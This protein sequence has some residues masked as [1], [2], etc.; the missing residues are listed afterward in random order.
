M[1][2]GTLTLASAVGITI[3][4]GA[5]GSASV[6]IVGTIASLNTAL[7]GLVYSPSASFTGNDQ[8]TITISDLG[9]TGGGTLTDTDIVPLAQNVIFGTEN[10]DLINGTAG[11]DLI[12]ARGGDDTI[13]AL[14]GNDV[15][16]GGDGNDIIR[17]GA[18]SNVDTDNVDAGLGNDEIHIQSGTNK[19]T[20]SAGAD[21]DQIYGETTAFSGSI[22]GG[23]GSDTLIFT[24]EFTNNFAGATFQGI[25]AT[26]LGGT[27]T[28]DTAQAGNLGT[29]DVTATSAAVTLAT[30]GTAF[31]G[32]GDGEAKH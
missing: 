24:N 5:N 4:G 13:N 1:N 2:A 21:N 25:E 27:L 26:S 6:T 28:I 20:I 29:I 30:A 11:L 16:N 7:D 10:N 8:L 12:I 22:D 32:G 18:G 19:G 3:T 9:H 23:S 15:V 14:A 17:T 31:W